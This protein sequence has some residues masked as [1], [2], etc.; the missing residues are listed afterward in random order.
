MGDKIKFNRDNLLLLF[1]IICMLIL[2]TKYEFISKVPDNEDLH[3]N[4]LTIS[5]VFSGFLFTSL[6]LLIGFIDRANMPELETAGYTS[7]YFNGV[8]MGIAIF[9]ISIFVSI[10]FIVFV[11]IPHEI[12][13]FNFEVFLLIGGVLFF[14]KAVYD[15]FKILR[16]VRKYVKDEYLQKQKI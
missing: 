14:I 8:L 4:L 7:K 16:K 1:L 15:V 13:V 12:K 2:A 10:S 6:G 9:L 11:E 3:F 5:T